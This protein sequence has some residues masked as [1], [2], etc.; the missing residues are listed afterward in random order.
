MGENSKIEWTDHTFNPGPG[1]RRSAP[2]AIIVTLK[3]GRRDPASF[4]GETIRV[5]ALLRAI[6]KSP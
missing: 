1:A 3:A 2:V 5:V 6:G 4:N